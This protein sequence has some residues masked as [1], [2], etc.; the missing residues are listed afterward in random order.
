MGSASGNHDEPRRGSRLRTGAEAAAAAL[1]IALAAGA[2]AA[3]QR[4]LDRHFL[5][6][7]FLPRP[8]YVAIETFARAAIAAS[9][10]SLIVARSRVGRLAARWR[11][12]AVGVAVAAALALGASEIVLDRF[13][14]R[15]AGWLVHEEEPR[16]RPDDRL[17]WI[18][19]PSREGTSRIGGRTITYAFDRHGYRARRADEAVDL[20]RPTIVFAGESVMFGEGLTWEETVPAQVGVQLG[21]QSANIAVHGFGNDQAYLRL[22]A[23]LP[24]FHHPVAVVS[25]FMSAL[26]GRNLD[27]DRPHLDPGL[28]WRPAADRGRLATLAGLLVPYRRDETVERGIIMTREVLRAT[29]AIARER[30][31]A[32]LIVVPQF[33]QESDVERTLRQ[34]VVAGAGIPAVTVEIDSSW[35]L[36]WD[37]HPNARAARLMAE[38]IAARL[39]DAP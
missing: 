29:V 25:L 26:F 20:E 23:E 1:G 15:A 33:G 31:A 7:W 12:R 14:I 24:R 2:I 27:D 28:V 9:G 18:P 8:W 21:V 3:N 5:P 34:R 35:R 37:R 22:Q 30:G 39:R 6:S 16:R 19:E 13:H 11:A 17:G 32:A 10:I 38:A 4:W 36:P